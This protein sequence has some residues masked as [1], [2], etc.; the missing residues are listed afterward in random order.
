VGD[1]EWTDCHRIS[2]GSYDPLERL[3]FIRQTFFDKPTTQG[4]HP[5]RVQRQG[6]LGEKFSENS[7]FI[8]ND[9]SFVALHVVGSNNNLVATEQQCTKKSNRTEADCQ[10]ATAEYVERNEAD[11]Q[12]LKDS[13]QEAREKKLAGIVIAI[14]ADVYFPFELS[15]GG[16]QDDFLPQLNDQNGFSD[17]FHTLA[18]ETKSFNGQVLLIH[19]DSHYLKIDKAMYQDDDTLTRN[20]TRVE[21]FG[22]LE[23][24]WVEM[25]VDPKAESLFRFIPVILEPISGNS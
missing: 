4:P 3:Y 19:G 15:D 24:S 17:F 22:D 10:M 11:I 14:Q 21:T 8:K 1:N 18:A 23:K 25:I 5:I 12:W 7:R 13:F 9:V 16:Y 20:F 6:K 2:N